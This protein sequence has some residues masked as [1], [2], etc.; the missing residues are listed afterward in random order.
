[1][2]YNQNTISRA[3]LRK[4]PVPKEF[5]SYR[6]GNGARWVPLQHGELAD[7]VIKE[8]KVA[9]LTPTNESW[10][11]CRKDAGLVG[12]I[13]FESLPGVKTPTGVS[14][15]LGLRHSNDGLWALTF[16]VGGRVMVCSNGIITGDFVLTR[17]HTSG[18][19]LQTSIRA[20]IDRFLQ[21]SKEVLQLVNQM[22]T[23][24]M[25]NI[26]GDSRILDAGEKKIIPWTMVPKVTS[27][28]RHPEHKE[29]EPRNAWSLYNAFTEAV[30]TRPPVQ[31]LQTVGALRG[32]L[33]A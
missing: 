33:A 5:P 7:A 27:N 28:W 4:I 25:D 23:I 9:N 21:D 14:S 26:V 16:V 30:K 13:D 12:S 24:E 2:L 1:M 17:K 6:A 15:S 29:F 3:E 22:K 31:Q 19:E 11:L 18:L 10:A 8:L 20:G 32:L